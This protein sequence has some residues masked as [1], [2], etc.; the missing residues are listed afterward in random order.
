MNIRSIQETLQIETAQLE[1][2][3]NF[4]LQ[5]CDD[6]YAIKCYQHTDESVVKVTHF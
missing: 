3:M 4:A 6:T 1:D 5:K 2:L